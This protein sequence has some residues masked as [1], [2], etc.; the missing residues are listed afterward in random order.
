MRCQ[1][2]QMKNTMKKSLFFL[3]TAVVFLS[4]SFTACA[5]EISTLPTSILLSQSSATVSPGE[6]L[7]L[8]ADLVPNETSIKTLSWS[9]SNPEVATVIDGEVRG[10]LEGMTVITVT[11]HS[12]QKSATCMVTVAYPVS[13][14]MLDKHSALLGI[15]ETIELTATVMP[16][17]APDKTVTWSSDDPEVAEVSANGMITAKAPGTTTIFAVTTVGYKQSSCY[18]KVYPENSKYMTMNILSTDHVAFAISGNG[19]AEIDWGDGSSFLTT[20]IGN[21]PLTIRYFYSDVFSPKVKIVGERINILNCNNIQITNLDVSK[22]AALTQLYCASNQLKSLDLSNNTLLTTLECSNNQLTNLDM[23][24]NTALSNLNCAFNLLS[25]DALNVLFGTLHNDYFGIGN[26][27]IYIG[28]N[29][30]TAQCDQSIA[31][32]SFWVV[33]D[34]L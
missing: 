25:T 33:H 13:Y 22:N 30:G 27:T 5:P 12:G 14:V 11:S 21:Y 10:I 34:G 32:S 9:S 31:T 8:T 18:V 15:G 16:E 7:V 2:I 1:F 4:V 3:T 23:T 28:N 17:D 6:T 29:P 24:N 20:T 19:T 26:K